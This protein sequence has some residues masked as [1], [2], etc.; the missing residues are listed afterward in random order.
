[1]P[2]VREIDSFR[3]SLGHIGAWVKVNKATAAVVTM[4]ALPTTEAAEGIIE[5]YGVGSVTFSP[6]IGATII[7]DGY[8]STVALHARYAT[9]AWKWDPVTREYN[10]SGYVTVT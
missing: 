1:M 4:D 10:L 8:V 9:A 2:I 7:C 3:L 6:G 5:W